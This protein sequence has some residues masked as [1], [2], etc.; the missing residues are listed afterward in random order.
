MKKLLLKTLL[1]A[2]VC[3]TTVSVIQFGISRIPPYSEG[4][5]L[6]APGISANIKIV[7][8][9]ILEGTSEIEI[10]LSGILGF[11]TK[12]VEVPFENMS[13]DQGVREV[14]CQ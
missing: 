2:C 8:N 1:I 12:K 13:G 6:S 10:S 7:K 9:N 5:C 11:M 4:T 14:S 3:F